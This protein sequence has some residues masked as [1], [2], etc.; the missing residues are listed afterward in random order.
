M[1]HRFHSYKPGGKY[2]S[3]QQDEPEKLRCRNHVP[4]DNELTLVAGS[5]QAARSRLFGFARIGHWS[6]KQPMDDIEYRPGQGRKD[7]RKDRHEP[8]EQGERKQ[9]FQREGQHHQMELRIQT[10]EERNR[11]L[12][13]QEQAQNGKDQTEARGENHAAQMDQ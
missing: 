6:G 12:R 13:H 3:E 9:H 11:N 8:G 7:P 1:N 5:R 4:G 10:R 2:G